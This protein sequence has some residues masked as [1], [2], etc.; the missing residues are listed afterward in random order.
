MS[1]KKT[2]AI[3]NV[4]I[5]K[6]AKMCK[7]CAKKGKGNHA[8]KHGLKIRDDK[9]RNYKFCIDCGDK[10]DYTAIKGDYINER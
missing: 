10:I 4:E 3:C 2:C 6:N 1:K 9:E 5:S 7:S 8:D